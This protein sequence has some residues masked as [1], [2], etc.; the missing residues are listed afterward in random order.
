M[1]LKW[2]SLEFG[3]NN[4]HVF[5]FPLPSKKN[6]T[7][8]MYHWWRQCRCLQAHNFPHEFVHTNRVFVLIV[9]VQEIM[10]PITNQ[11]RFKTSNKKTDHSQKALSLYY[12][13][14]S[15]RVYYMSSDLC[16]AHTIGQLFRVSL[17]ASFIG[18]G[19]SGEDMSH[20]I[21][22]Q[23]KSTSNLLFPTSNAL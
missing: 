3:E 18:S 11:Q 2:K 21:C 14:D 22:Q 5:R 12:L 16:M 10:L 13:I 7:Q 23:K 17:L 4:I 6:K 1:V 20:F 9:V 15:P 8:K 19:N